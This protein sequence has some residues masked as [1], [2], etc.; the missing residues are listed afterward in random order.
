M[1]EHVPAVLA[2]LVRERAKDLCEFCLLPQATQE[3]VFHIDHIQPRSKGGLTVAGNLCQACVTCSLRKAARTHAVDPESRVVVP[4]FHPRRYRW[5]DHFAWATD[6][7]LLGTSPTGRA[8]IRALG[9]NRP[10][11]LII[12][13]G[14]AKLRRF[15][16]IDRPSR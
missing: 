12:R 8:T 10:D 7:R 5:H 15:P 16:P 1:S 14:L 4:L 13:R 9:M 6:W 3:A 11:I 2:A